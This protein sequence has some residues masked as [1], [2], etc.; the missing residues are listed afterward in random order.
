MRCAAVSVRCS[1]ADDRT[2]SGEFPE[3]FGS[4]STFNVGIEGSSLVICID[5]V[6]E[7][8]GLKRI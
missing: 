2:R 1:P 3:K 8:A 4:V 7:V 5:D 6:E